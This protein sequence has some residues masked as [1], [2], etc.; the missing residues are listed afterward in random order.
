MQNS[1]L[2]YFG[3]ILLT[4]LLSEFLVA[5]EIK[6]VLKFYD[7]VKNYSILYRGKNIV[8]SSVSLAFLLWQ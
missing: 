6:V 5:K 1:L 4:T 7:L 8:F 2:T 3:K